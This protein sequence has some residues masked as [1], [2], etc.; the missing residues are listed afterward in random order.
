[1]K[2]LFTFWLAILF[3]QGVEAQSGIILD[4]S[5]VHNYT[6]RYYDYEGEFAQSFINLTSKNEKWSYSIWSNFGLERQ[7]NV[8]EYAPYL[9]RYW[10]IGD[11]GAFGL[12]ATYYFISPQVLQ[13]SVLDY[14]TNSGEVYLQY[15]YDGEFSLAS[16]NF[17]DPFLR[18]FYGTVDLKKPLLGLVGGELGLYLKGGIQFGHPGVKNGFSNGYAA[19]EWAKARK[20]ETTFSFVSGVMYLNSRTQPLWQNKIMVSF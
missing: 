7:T 3:L 4:I 9:T 8:V 16:S 19:F 18:A 11:K 10:P 13:D 2:Y 17:F 5:A 6:W 14:E 12:G 15:F 20:K 1:M